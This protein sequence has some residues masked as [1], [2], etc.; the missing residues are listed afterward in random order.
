MAILTINLPNRPKDDPTEIVG[1]GLFANGYNYEVG[2]LIP[3][4]VVHGEELDSAPVKPEDTVPVS[5][6]L[7][8]LM[9]LTHA[10]LDA[11][12]EESKVTFD[13]NMT[14]REKAE[15]LLGSPAADP[16][17]EVDPTTEGDS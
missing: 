1:L 16:A 2:D 6:E 3:E 7:K 4:D 13:E 11:Q 8:A 9:K 5:P 12:A 17:V 10:E 15:A 14:K